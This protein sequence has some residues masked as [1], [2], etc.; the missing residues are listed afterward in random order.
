MMVGK[1]SL[2]NKELQN[3]ILK[4]KEFIYEVL[5]PEDYFINYLY[6]NCKSFFLLSKHEGFGIPVIEAGA[7]GSKLVL[8]DIPPLKEIA[9]ENALFINCNSIIEDTSVINITLGLV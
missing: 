3:K 2:K 4:H 5:N 8:N 7:Q 9:P 6:K 1:S